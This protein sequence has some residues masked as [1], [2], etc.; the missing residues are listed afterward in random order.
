MI[1]PDGLVGSNT[2]PQPLRAVV[3]PDRVK[4]VDFLAEIWSKMV[5]GVNETEMVALP[6]TRNDTGMSRALLEYASQ[7]SALWP[8]PVNTRVYMMDQNLRYENTRNRQACQLKAPI[9]RTKNAM[10][11]P[12]YENR[13]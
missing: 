11:L 1:F 3:L 7:I 4:D 10:G 8:L 5:K 13:C 12:E 2:E 9:H 6:S